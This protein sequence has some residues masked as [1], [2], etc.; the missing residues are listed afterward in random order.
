MEHIEYTETLHEGVLNDDVLHKIKDGYH[1][2][3][4]HS[5]GMY[6]VVYYTYASEWHNH[7][8][9]FIAKTYEN[10]IKRY[11]KETGRLI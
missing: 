2:S 7:K 11:Q 1:F 10:A 3:N 5:H 8:H 4:G 9:Q 6:L